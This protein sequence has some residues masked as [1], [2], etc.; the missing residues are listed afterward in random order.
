M[1]LNDGAKLFSKLNSEQTKLRQNL[2]SVIK[3]NTWKIVFH[4]Y[5][6]LFI[7]IT[8]LCIPFHESLHDSTEM[9]LSVKMFKC[10]VQ[11]Q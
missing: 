5:S 10:N 9:I 11:M 3:N 7:H 6:F 2:Y 8:K 1:Q 4:F